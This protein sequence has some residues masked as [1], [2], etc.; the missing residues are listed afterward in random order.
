M[1]HRA[2]PDGKDLNVGITG[3]PSQRQ[4]HLGSHLSVHP[5]ATMLAYGE[6]PLTVVKDTGNGVCN[7]STE[8]TGLVSTTRIMVWMLVCPS[9]DTFDITCWW[10]W[11]HHIPGIKTKGKLNNNLYQ[12]WGC[13]SVMSPPLRGDM[14][15][16]TDW[17]PEW[18]VTIGVCLWAGNPAIYRMQ[19]QP[20]CFYASLPL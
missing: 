10:Q 11:K 19:V 4:G 6:D 9:C 8:I 18:L 15:E 7:Y 17:V 16:S 3:P 1:T 5:P 20:S 14:K 2:I 13:N 12:S